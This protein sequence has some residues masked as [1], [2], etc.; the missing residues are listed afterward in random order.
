MTVIDRDGFAAGAPSKSV[1]WGT[2]MR[3]PLLLSCALATLAFAAQANEVV[4]VTALRETE[5]VGAVGDAADDPAISLGQTP[6]D[7]R[8]IGTQ[9]KGG[10]YVYDLTGKVVQSAL[11]GRPNNVDVREGFPWSDGAAP[12]VATS[13][14]ADNTIAI[15]RFD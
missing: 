14:R 5:P 1:T 10:L 12:I 2:A 8:I 13:D 15:Y 6:A 4:N 7:T 9:K 3:F 11:S